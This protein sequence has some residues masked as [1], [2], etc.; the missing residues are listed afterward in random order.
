M[1]RIA[2]FAIAVSVMLLGT[3]GLAQSTNYDFDRAANF[4]RYRTYAWTS[5]TELTDDLNHARVVR[6]IERELLSKGLARV[7]ASA[8]PDVLVAYHASFDK[9]LRLDGYS[10]GWGGPRFGGLRS[11]TATIQ[12]VVTGTLVV[13]VRDAAS[14]RIVWR[15][16]ASTEIDPSAKP[17]KR[18]KMI[19][20]ATQKLFKNYPPEA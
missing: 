8:N 14:R 12:E 3:I 1:M 18:E 10:S 2:T 11:G 5:G 7:D 9:N 17:D 16:L 4:S 15:G 20:K 6:A 19:N 13:D